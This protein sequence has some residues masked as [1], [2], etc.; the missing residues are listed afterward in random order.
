MDSALAQ[1]WRDLEVIISDD[2]SDERCLPVLNAFNDPR[3]RVLKNSHQG[4]SAARNAAIAAARGKYIVSLDSDD[5][6]HPTFVEKGLQC[7]RADDKLGMV[8][9]RRRYFGSNCNELR[10]RDITAENILLGL[11]HSGGFGM[12]RKADWERTA[13]YDTNLRIFED[14]DFW[15]QLLELGRSFK[16]IEEVLYSYREH[17]GSTMVKFN[18]SGG[19]YVH[20]HE[21]DPRL[22]L[23]KK[24]Q[25]LY[26]SYPEFLVGRIFRQPDK[27]NHIRSKRL[28]YR[29]ILFLNTIPLVRLLV[30]GRVEKAARKLEYLG[31]FTA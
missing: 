13:G 29:C 1:T 17:P 10:H 12:F 25:A 2:G 5:K 27:P 23:F 20:F 31:H 28:K 11:A 21:F 14:W 6:L 4:V 15:L 22:Y 30:A 7:M 16:R 3:I 26:L 19:G 8:T 18:N 24:H 9:C